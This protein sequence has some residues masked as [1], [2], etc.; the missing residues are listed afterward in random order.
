MKNFLLASLLLLMSAT[1]SA[2]Q[3]VEETAVN[4]MGQPFIRLINN[5]PYYASCYL[6]DSYNYL[7]F[8]IAPGSVSMWYPI[9]GFYVWECRG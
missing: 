5:T 6:R 7:T 8:V 9:Y 2:Q 3:V 1:V 4:N